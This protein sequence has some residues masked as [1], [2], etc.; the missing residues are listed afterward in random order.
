M[1]TFDHAGSDPVKEAQRALD[2]RASLQTAT[3]RRTISKI[4]DS[5][6]WRDRSDQAGSK[7]KTFGSFATSR[8]PGGLGVRC[9][10][11]LLDM[12]NALL[13]GG[14]YAEWV[15]VMEPFL[16][17]RGRPKNVIEGEEFLP[18]HII[19]RSYGQ[20]DRLLLTLKRDHSE[21]F[22]DVCAGKLSPAQGAIRAGIARDP[23]ASRTIKQFAALSVDEQ[24]QF[25]QAI[26]EPVLGPR[27]AERWRQSVK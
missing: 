4:I 26:L 19:S 6:A 7:F 9:N 18:P 5:G 14:Y 16:R 15:D 10:E 27:L 2:N 22:A 21:I 17:E 3:L 20:R 25:I 23:R 11:T 12:R 8:R 24:C 13:A 1:D